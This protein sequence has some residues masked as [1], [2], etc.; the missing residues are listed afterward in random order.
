[1]KIYSDV[2]V[3]RRRKR[4]NQVRQSATQTDSTQSPWCTKIA[5]DSSTADASSSCFLNDTLDTETCDR[6]HSEI[7]LKPQSHASNKPTTKATPSDDAQRRRKTAARKRA[8][9]RRELHAAKS[10]ATVVGV[11]A[12]CWLP[13]H[14][15]HAV[16]LFCKHCREPYMI[17]DITIL[18]SHANSLINPIIYAYRMRDFRDA[19]SKLFAQAPFQLSKTS[20]FRN[21][22]VSGA[23]I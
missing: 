10:L 5:E 4:L 21:A 7:F 22:S 19:F 23:E 16:T 18:L 8:L 3:K 15:L 1:M 9:L 2:T 20:C 17:L 12:F 6:L 14:L 13:L 11:F